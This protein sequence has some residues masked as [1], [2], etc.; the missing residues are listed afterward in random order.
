MHLISLK[1]GVIF[2]A[3]FVAV[4]LAVTGSHYDAYAHITKR[5]ANV[6]L[7]VGWLNEPPI[8]GELDSVTI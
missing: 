3:F 7:E 8:A 1:S 5:F 4:I 6:T 2:I